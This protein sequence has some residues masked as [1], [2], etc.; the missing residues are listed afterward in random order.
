MHQ[1]SQCLLETTFDLKPTG[2]ISP[3]SVAW[4]LS[5]YRP[6]L[7]T[8]REFFSVFDTVVKWRLGREE[9]ISTCGMNLIVGFCSFLCGWVDEAVVPGVEA[10]VCSDGPVAE[11]LGVIS[12]GSISFAAAWATADTEPAPCNLFPLLSDRVRVTIVLAFGVEL[13]RVKAGASERD[14]DNNRS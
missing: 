12:S 10:F 6:T 9:R 8:P 1:N 14:D 5:V 2:N 13:D 7:I 3:V 4:S 11:R